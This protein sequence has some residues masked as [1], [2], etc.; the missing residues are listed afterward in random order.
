[1]LGM[2]SVTEQSTPI[3][4]KFEVQNKNTH[5]NQQKNKNAW[6]LEYPKT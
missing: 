5:T 3:E 4:V 1:M 2:C 6:W